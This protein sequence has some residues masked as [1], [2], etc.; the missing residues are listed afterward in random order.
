MATHSPLGSLLHEHRVIRRVVEFFAAESRAIA[1]GALV[2]HGLISQATS[3]ITDFA[4]PY[5]HG[6]EEEI[7]FARLLERD[8]PEELRAQ[9]LDL[10]H[11]HAEVRRMTAAVAE[12]NRRHLAGEADAVSTLH[13]W[14]SELADIYTE[15]VHKEDRGYFRATLDY[16]DDD[17]K[18]A[19]RRDFDDFDRRI[20]LLRYESLAEELEATAARPSAEDGGL[21]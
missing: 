2:R 15:H 10:I 3:F 8:I 1:D 4:D 20:T 19:M 12:E 17:E 16:F 21:V 9:T 18:D 6:K 7:L 11:E 5:H 13:E 14:M